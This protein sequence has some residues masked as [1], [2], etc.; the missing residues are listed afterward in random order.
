MNQSKQKA[1]ASSAVCRTFKGGKF[2]PFPPSSDTLGATRRLLDGVE[3][4]SSSCS[5]VSSEAAR[6][7]RSSADLKGYEVVVVLQ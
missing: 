4:I 1:I 5:S 2:S 7:W 3:L 6:G